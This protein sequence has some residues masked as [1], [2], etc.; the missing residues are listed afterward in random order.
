MVDGREV[1]KPIHKLRPNAKK[2]SSPNSKCQLHKIQYPL[3]ISKYPCIIGTWSRTKQGLE[4][5]IKELGI[6]PEDRYFQKCHFLNHHHQKSPGD[7]L[8][9]QIPGFHSRSQGSESLRCVCL[10]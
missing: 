8:N 4:S 10:L 5:Q 9:M 6:H 3:K 7:L 1:S 2:R